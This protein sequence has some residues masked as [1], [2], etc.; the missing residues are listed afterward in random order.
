MIS[1]N[2]KMNQVSRLAKIAGQSQMEKDAFAWTPAIMGGL[3]MIG[4]LNL[5][6]KF[7]I[8]WGSELLGGNNLSSTIRALSKMQELRQ[9]Q[10]EW[11]MGY[12]RMHQAL[13]PP[14]TQPNATQVSENTNAGLSSAS[15]AVGSVE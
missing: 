1:L 14:S 5:L 10:L 8:N 12:S 15:A 7:G 9:Q 6:R 3:G 2:E 4:L 13:E 11:E